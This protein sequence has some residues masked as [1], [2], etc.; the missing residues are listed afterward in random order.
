[1]STEVPYLARLVPFR[2]SQSRQARRKI[3]ITAWFTFPIILWLLLWLS[4]NTG[5]WNLLDF[6]SGLSG[7]ITA[8]RASFPLIVF[9]VAF[10]SLISRGR[11]RPRTW[12]EMGFWIYGFVML[13]ACTGADDWFDYAYWGFA[14]LAT[15]AVVEEG[16][17][18]KDPLE[19]ATR[20]NWLSWLVTGVALVTM[21]F[22]A[23]SV[24]YDPDTGSGY[25]LVNRFQEA[26]GYGIARET[27]LS[28][29]A[30]VPA[31]ISLV[32]LFSG[33]AWQRVLSLAVFIGSIYVIW[34]MQSRGAFFAFA[35]A[36][37]FVLWFADKRNQKIVVSLFALLVIVA[38]IAS[39]SHEG[40]QGGL[41]DLW[42]H[43]TRNEGSEAFSSMSGRDYI[44]QEAMEQWSHS[45]LIG[46]GPQADRLFFFNA[47]SAVIYALL[48]SGL[49]GAV[50]FV[51]AFAS[52]W[53]ALLA[54]IPKI[55]QLPSQERI[56]LQITGAILVFSTLRSYPE[57]QAAVFSVDMLL[58]YPAMIYLGVLWSRTKRARKTV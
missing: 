13:L 23:R 44:W 28:R 27:G 19:F 39:S 35:G 18:S 54:L 31:I 32:F 55:R 14:F 30:A 17:R 50:F 48:C 22:L 1:M 15:L 4:I 21:L 51:I 36:F 40:L 34:V 3:D 24:L 16:L 52:S 41:H 6:G 53:W 10:V 33:Q 20:L 9:I 42:L 37:L 26:Y 12:V 58:Q 56:M 49:I 2:R 8:A 11:S 46:Y 57:N 5:P 45:P 25:G 47:Q 43:V 29:M 38:L 7:G